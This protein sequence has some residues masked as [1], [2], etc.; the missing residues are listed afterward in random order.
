MR[1]KKNKSYSKYI[2]SLL[3]TSIVILMLIF[4]GP[5]SAIDISIGSVSDTTPTIGDLVNFQITIDYSAAG[6]RLN[7]T[8]FNVSV[9]SVGNCTYYVING[10][11]FGG[12]SA[13]CDYLNASLVTSMSNSFSY[14]ALNSY[15]Y[16][17][18]SASSKI[19]TS[20]GVSGYG[21]TYSASNSGDYYV[22]NLTL[23]TSNMSAGSYEID[24]VVSSNGGSTKFWS[25]DAQDV[26]L[27][28][29]AAATTSTTNS[30]GGGNGL[31]ARVI[32]PEV[33]EPI[34]T[35]REDVPEEAPEPEIASNEV[36]VDNMAGA[37]KETGL[38]GLIKNNVSVISSGTFIGIVVGLIAATVIITIIISIRRRKKVFY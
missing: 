4:S 21:Y 37:T 34:S 5:V 31:I 38:S 12:D 2:V 16:T 28:V 35:N 25:S 18:E 23:N 11:E 8:T 33:S 19:N 1:Y 7:F 14:G 32:V 6:E 30:G 15:G 36:A 26:S 13:L 22:Y 27:T 24:V 10:S 9:P 17:S 3:T 29:S 20:F